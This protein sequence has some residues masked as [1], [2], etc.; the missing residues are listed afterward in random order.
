MLPDSPHHAI[1]CSI[2]RPHKLF[3]ASDAAVFESRDLGATWS[4][5]SG[6]LPNAMF[7][8]LVY[9]EKDRT[10]TVATYGRSMW[11]LKIR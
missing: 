8:D 9:H 2:G 4:N 11:R 3:V 10:L 6:D 7:V 1:A 5:I